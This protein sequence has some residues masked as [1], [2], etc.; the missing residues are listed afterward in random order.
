MLTLMRKL[1]TV[2]LKLVVSVCR[3]E[4]TCVMRVIIS[5][6]V[7]TARFADCKRINNVNSLLAELCK[8]ENVVFFSNPAFT[9]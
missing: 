5:V 8:I 6:I 7:K 1:L 9:T 4:W 3:V 2:F